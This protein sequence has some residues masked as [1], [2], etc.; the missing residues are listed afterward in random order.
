[1]IV[2]PHMLLG[3]A[4]EHWEYR[5]EAAHSHFDSVVVEASAEKA[6]AVAS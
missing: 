5:A 4:V 6:A 1:M 2:A 3:K